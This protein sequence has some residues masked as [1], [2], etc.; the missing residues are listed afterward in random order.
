VTSLAL[1]GILAASTIGCPEIAREFSGVVSCGLHCPSNSN[2]GQPNE[3]ILDVDGDGNLDIVALSCP[4]G[5]QVPQALEFPVYLAV[6]SGA[7]TD[8]QVAYAPESLIRKIFGQQGATNLLSV[9]FGTSSVKFRS[10]GRKALVT[11]CW[12]LSVVHLERLQSPLKD[13]TGEHG[14]VFPAPKLRGKAIIVTTGEVR[15]AVY[16]DGSRFRFHPQWEW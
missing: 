6:F 16:W 3:L 9:I 7:R 1:I 13:W 12:S 10:S 8:N 4:T 5:N 2:I 14:D 11:R 15:D